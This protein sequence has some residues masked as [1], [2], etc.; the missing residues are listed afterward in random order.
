[1]D[2]LDLKYRVEDYSKI[3]WPVSSLHGYSSTGKL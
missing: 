2:S 3:C 1:M